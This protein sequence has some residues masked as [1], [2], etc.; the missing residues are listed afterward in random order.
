MTVQ[1]HPLG[2]LSIHEDM[3]VQHYVDKWLE[4]CT[5]ELPETEKPLLTRSR[6]RQ[7]ILQE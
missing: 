6:K 5:D 2:G 1:Y 3:D 7:W 4:T